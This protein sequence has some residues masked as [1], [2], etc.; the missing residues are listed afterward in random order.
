MNTENRSP[1]TRK[2][3]TWPYSEFYLDRRAV[4]VDNIVSS[5]KDGTMSVPYQGFGTKA[6]PAQGALFFSSHRLH[7]KEA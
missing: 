7:K 5:F 2:S 3:G 1:N 6:F 4:F